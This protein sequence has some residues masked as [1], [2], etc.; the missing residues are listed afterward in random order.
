MRRYSNTRG[1]SIRTIKRFCADKNI[2]RTSRLNE[3]ELDEVSVCENGISHTHTHTIF[4]SVGLF[5]CTV[6]SIYVCTF[7]MMLLMKSDHIALLMKW[8]WFHNSHL[9]RLA[10]PMGVRP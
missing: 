4:S 5:V 1:F 8:S 2:H 3:D 9:H 6:Y 10:P 7:I